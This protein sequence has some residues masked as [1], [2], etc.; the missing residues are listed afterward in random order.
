MAYRYTRR[1][2]GSGN[3][4]TRK[5][6]SGNGHIDVRPRAEQRSGASGT[7]A[8]AR[9]QIATAMS[10]AALLPP[11]FYVVLTSR[12]IALSKARLSGALTVNQRAELNRWLL[13][14]TLS[15][16]STWLRSMERCVV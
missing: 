15:V 14:R 8:R 13:D 9:L 3:P 16:L 5:A 1:G 6:R 7:R 12:G 2:S 11:D 4:R 10:A